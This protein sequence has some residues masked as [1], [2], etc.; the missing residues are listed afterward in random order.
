MERT[1]IWAKAQGINSSWFW[2][3][4]RGGAKPCIPNRV[5]PTRGNEPDSSES[6]NNLPF[7][8]TYLGAICIL[9]LH[10]ADRCEAM[11]VSTDT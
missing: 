1:M 5:A 9:S 8:Q 6:F 10:V 4:A 3:Q 11:A 2:F 7:I